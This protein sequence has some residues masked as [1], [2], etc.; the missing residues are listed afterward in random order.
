M[1]DA[2]PPDQAHSSSERQIGKTGMEATKVLV[3]ACTTA[4][5]SALL[6]MDLDAGT[7]ECLCDWHIRGLHVAADCLYVARMRDDQTHLEKY[8]RDGLAWVRRIAECTDTHSVTTVGNQI[9]LCSTG[10]NQV[11]FL[12]AEGR[13]LR[14]WSPDERAEGD[15]WHLNSLV[16]QDGRLVVSCFGQ[17][18]RFRGWCG[19]V[20]GAGRVLE[21]P[22]GRV[23][24]E[25][26]T[27]PHDPN[28]VAGGWVVNESVE[29]RLMSHPDGAPPQVLAHLPGFP[30]GLH[31]LRD[32]FVV[33]VSGHRMARDQVNEGRVVL[34][35]RTAGDL[36][37]S[38]PI[39]YREIGHIVPAPSAEVLAG[40]AYGRPELRTRFH[41]PIRVL[42][43]SDRVGCLEIVAPPEPNPSEPHLVS[44]PVRLTNRSSKTWSSSA[45]IC[46]KV[47]YQLLDRDG[48]RLRS[49]GPW[50]ELPI[51]LPPGKTLTFPIVLDVSL[52]KCPAEATGLLITLV[53]EKTAWWCESSSWTPARLQPPRHLVVKT[54]PDQGAAA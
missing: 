24:L 52:E 42:T 7:Y 26:L 34:L 54:S 4:D 35:R 13:E 5:D 36:V 9:A 30:R 37:Q 44:L 1:P 17:F 15:S 43:E 6:L 14:R 47:S 38:I 48:D 53:Q 41:S 28:R 50:T 25:G 20:G 22:S 8:D 39:P 11:I 51:P 19:R 3:T 21:V 10:T 16:S 31:L 32:Y 33:G 2:K 29:S 12:D 40:L 23:L 27:G 46:L 45:P 49:R 18:D